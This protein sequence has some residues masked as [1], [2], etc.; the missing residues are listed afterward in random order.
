MNTCALKRRVTTKNHL[1]ILGLLAVLAGCGESDD[2]GLGAGMGG[3]PS[4][5]GGAGVG[6][7]TTAGSGGATAPVQTGGVPGS[8]GGVQ[9]SGGSIGSGG[10]VGVGGAASGGVSGSTGGVSTSGGVMG[11]GGET[12]GSGGTTATGGSTGSGGAPPHEDLGVGDGKDVVLLGDSW[13]SNTLQIEG[14]GGGIAPALIKAGGKPYRNYAVQGVMLLSAS[15]FGPAIPSQWD[16]AVRANP[17]IKTV[18]MTAGGNDIIQNPTIQSA[19]SSGGDACKELLQKESDALNTLWTK[20]ADGGV[21][22]IVYIQYADDVG[23]VDP[24]VRD[25]GLK[26]P[27]ICLSGK[28]RCHSVNPTT[29]IMHQIAGDNIH[30]L[31]AANT[32]VAKVVY[33]LMT[34]EGMRR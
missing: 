17:V 28:V 26:T 11:S 19:C 33:D 3:M 12:P 30:P 25:S 2:G 23:T 13:M 15:A 14:T 31:A 18:V 8:G 7:A 21:L 4:A 10:V 34:S 27:A 20:M 16:S 32:R 1:S 22:D 24:S 29:A 5:T 6:G 9:A